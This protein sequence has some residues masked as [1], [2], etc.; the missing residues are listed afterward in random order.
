MNCNNQVV[1]IS[2][3]VNGGYGLARDA[4]GRAVLVSRTGHCGCG[5]IAHFEIEIVVGTVAVHVL[6]GSRSRS[7]IRK[8]ESLLAM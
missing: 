7:P 1:D 5:G 4:D 8:N 3:I 6:S 2:K